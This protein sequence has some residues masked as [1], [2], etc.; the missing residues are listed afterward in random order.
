MLRAISAKQKPV[1]IW[2]EKVMC[3]NRFKPHLP[4]HTAGP[5]VTRVGD[6]RDTLSHAS[7]QELLEAGDDLTTR[8]AGGLTYC[9]VTTKAAPPAV[10][11]TSRA[12]SDPSQLTKQLLPCQARHVIAAQHKE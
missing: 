7:Y 12:M 11:R 10:L 3:K 1:C 8:T 4:P 5:L 9:V 6:L 2:G